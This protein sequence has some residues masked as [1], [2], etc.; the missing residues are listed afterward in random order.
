MRTVARS[1]HATTSPVWG[2]LTSASDGHIAKGKGH[3]N[4]SS[5]SPVS[6]RDRHSSR[7]TVGVAF[8]LFAQQHDVHWRSDARPLSV[9]TLDE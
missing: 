4:R 9:R 5:A 1:L 2:I 6:E 8:E 7:L 3:V